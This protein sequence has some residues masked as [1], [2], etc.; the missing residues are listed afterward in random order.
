MSEEQKPLLYPQV[1]P[2]DPNLVATQT[3]TGNLSPPVLN[4]QGSG[5]SLNI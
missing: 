4:V 1:T 2:V 5:I 3:N